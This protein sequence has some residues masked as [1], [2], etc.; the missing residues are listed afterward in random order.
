MDSCDDGKGGTLCRRLPPLLRQKY[1][2]TEGN[3]A[4]K[5]NTRKILMIRIWMIRQTEW[6]KF[7]F[8]YGPTEVSL[9]MKLLFW[10]SRVYLAWQIWSKFGIENFQLQSVCPPKFCALGFMLESC[11]KLKRALENEGLWKMRG[12]RGEEKSHHRYNAKMES[13]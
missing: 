11:V 12:L 8:S 3:L 2:I 5:Y 10:A 1:G 9:W 13:I 6:G 4:F 7:I